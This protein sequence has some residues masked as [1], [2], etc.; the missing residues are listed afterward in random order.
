RF[1]GRTATT[2]P[3]ST[4]E[5]VE[6]GREGLVGAA[7]CCSLRRNGPVELAPEAY[8]AWCGGMTSAL[9][10]RVAGRCRFTLG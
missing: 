1:N 2:P 7:R 4:S 10:R 9:F 6:A 5:R 8:F 3:R